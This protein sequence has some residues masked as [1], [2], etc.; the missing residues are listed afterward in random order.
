MVRF[1]S[2]TINRISMFGLIALITCLLQTVIAPNIRLWSVA[3]SFAI[4]VTVL[5]GM[6]AGYQTGAVFGAILGFLCDAT[7]SYL[8]G[9]MSLLLMF[10]GLLAGFLAVRT[11]WK[12]LPAAALTLFAIYLGRTIISALEAVFIRFHPSAMIG[13]CVVYL[14]EFCITLLFL[15]PFYFLVHL[16]MQKLEEVE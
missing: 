11:L 15:A 9:S 12:S 14:K 5:V 13:P 7:T 10:S 2:H 6:H 4:L 16:A 8:V 3:P 1:D